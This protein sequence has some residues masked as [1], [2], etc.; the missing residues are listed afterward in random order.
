MRRFLAF[1]VFVTAATTLHA[2]SISYTAFVSCSS[3]V[4]VYLSWFAE[5]S[6]VYYAEVDDSSGNSILYLN[7]PYPAV[8]TGSILSDPQVFSGL[9]GSTLSVLTHGQVGINGLASIESIASEKTTPAILQ[10]SAGCT[11][12]PCLDLWDQGHQNI[13]DSTPFVAVAVPEPGVWTLTATG[14]GLLLVGGRRLRRRSRK[15]N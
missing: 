3:C 15:L 2:S 14:F 10:S 9:P 6:P 1:A 13:I 11:N 12:F 8:S 4:T 5:P 7:V